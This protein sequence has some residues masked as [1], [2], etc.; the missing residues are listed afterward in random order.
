MTQSYHEER[1][2]IEHDVPDVVTDITT[3]DILHAIRTV[4]V[5]N[6]TMRELETAFDESLPSGFDA[7]AT[8]KDAYLAGGGVFEALTR[9]A[10]RLA[11][12]IHVFVY[13]IVHPLSSV[14]TR[15]ITREQVARVIL[16]I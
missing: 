15:D 12:A 4:G 14:V 5:F 9:E 3:E 7:R 11:D 13:Q 10:P 16:A 8:V 1:R 6:R 2:L